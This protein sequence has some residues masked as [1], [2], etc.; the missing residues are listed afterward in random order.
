MVYSENPLSLSA[1]S[2]TQLP[3]I[4]NISTSLFVTTIETQARSTGNVLNE[5][6][7]FIST[8]FTSRTMDFWKSGND[9]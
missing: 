4:E 3:T 9:W 7:M 1:L 6:L 2:V 5:G 8:Y